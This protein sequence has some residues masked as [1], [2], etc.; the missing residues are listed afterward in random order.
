MIC[1]HTACVI[2]FD[3]LKAFTVSPSNLKLVSLLS[4]VRVK[5]SAVKLNW[6]TTVHQLSYCLSYSNCWVCEDGDLKLLLNTMWSPHARNPFC[7]V[8][9]SRSVKLTVQNVW[10]IQRILSVPNSWMDIC[11]QI[12]VLAVETH[13]HF[14]LSSKWKPKAIGAVF[15]WWGSKC[16]GTQWTICGDNKHWSEELVQNYLPS[17]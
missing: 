6:I 4:C 11:V 8:V 5:M 3:W 15:F 9:T 1:L 2:L 16:V 12:N 14:S 7:T 10:N 13:L 17:G